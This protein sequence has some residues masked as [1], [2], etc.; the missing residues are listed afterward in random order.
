MRK[1]VS[2][3]VLGAMVLAFGLAFFGTAGAAFAADSSATV[4]WPTQPI[5]L[6]VPASTGG[7]TDI[8]MR[9]LAEYITK[10]TGQAVVITNMT[11]LAGYEKVRTSKP[12]GYNYVAGITGLLIS[13]AQGDLNFGWDAFDPVT[14][15]NSDT[16]TGIVVHKNSPYQTIGKLLDAA[17][18]NPKKITG[19]ISMTGYPYLYILALKKSLGIDLYFVDAGNTAERNTALLGKQVDY[20]VTNAI[21]AKAFLASGDFKFIATAGKKRNYF[22]PNTPT[23]L[24]SGYKFDFTGQSAYIFASKGTDPAIIEAFNKLLQEITADKE[25][26]AR[27]LAMNSEPSI[28]T[29][30]AETIEDLKEATATFEFYIE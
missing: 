23:F 12:N 19:G 9:L 17:K 29:S 21:A 18:A 11:G 15:L 6:L 8:S 5:N 2:W 3:R 7:A 1:N 4:K 26:Q 25:Y 27:V 13:K 22:L 24:E 30:V 10:K 28:A 14:R 20:I 16:S